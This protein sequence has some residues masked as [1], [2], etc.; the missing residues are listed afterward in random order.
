MCG[1]GGRGEGEK[2][3]E[4]KCTQWSHLPRHTKTDL[5]PASITKNTG[6]KEGPGTC[7]NRNVQWKALVGR[8]GIKLQS[9]QQ[10]ST[11]ASFASFTRY[12][13]RLRQ[14]LHIW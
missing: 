14:T 6:G 5:H 7:A 13:S 1:G 12:L 8:W 4:D 11:I 10:H 9:T 2:E 3:R